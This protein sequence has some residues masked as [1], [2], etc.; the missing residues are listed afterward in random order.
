[1]KIL[2][3]SVSW[4]GETDMISAEDILFNLL[5]DDITQ[6]STIEL[7]TINSL[8]ALKEAVEDTKFDLFDT[9]ISKIRQEQL[10]D[11]DSKPD[12]YKDYKYNSD[13][14]LY[15]INRGKIVISDSLKKQT[16]TVIHGH[17]NDPSVT[18]SV[19]KL[20]NSDYFW[21][22]MRKN[23]INHIKRCPACQKTPHVPKN[24]IE[25]SGSFWADRPFARLNANTIRPLQQ[26][27][28]GFKY[29]IVFVD[30]FTRYTILPWKGIECSRGNQSP[31]MECSINFWYPTV[32]S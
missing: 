20:L 28:N 1:M 16:S 7:P 17:A 26:D 27:D 11:V 8:S 31:P 14:Q 2:K 19:K 24:V 12:Y 4:R 25:S 21:P 5:R 32:D 9:W 22:D 13:I 30:S 10:T 15:T 18:T 6:P 3:E 29:L 23:M